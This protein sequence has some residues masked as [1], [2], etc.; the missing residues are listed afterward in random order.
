MWVCVCVG[1]GYW[2]VFGGVGELGVVAK[3][4]MQEA[5]RR[6]RFEKRLYE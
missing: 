6:K 3:F 5:N 4:Y 1:G 2:D